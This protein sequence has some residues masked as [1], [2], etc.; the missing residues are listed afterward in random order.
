[1]KRTLKGK[2]IGLIDKYPDY[3]NIKCKDTTIGHII[4]MIA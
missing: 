1:M 2:G 3:A 4:V